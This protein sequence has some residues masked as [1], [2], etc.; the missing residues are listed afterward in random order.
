MTY[1]PLFPRLFTFAYSSTLL[2]TT[3][4]P[5]IVI[6]SDEPSAVARND[7]TLNS[8][9]QCTNVTDPR[10]HPMGTGSCLPGKVKRP[11]RESGNSPPS[12]AE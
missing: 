12:S 3:L 10:A 1:L 9:D 7:V 4:S 2:P 11:E 6:Q 8:G 5:F